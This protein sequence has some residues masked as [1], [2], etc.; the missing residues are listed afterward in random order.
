MIE[1]EALKS[2][3]F[4]DNKVKNIKWFHGHN[5]DS[6]PEEKAREMNKFFA[7]SDFSGFTG[8]TYDWRYDAVRPETYNG[9]SSVHLPC[10]R[11]GR[12]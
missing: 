5:A 4:S 6:T 7:D 10:G 2:R 9:S 12:P 3:L 8:T 1:L 11:T